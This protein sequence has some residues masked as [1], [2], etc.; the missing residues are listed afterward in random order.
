MPHRPIVAV[1][2]DDADIRELLAAYLAAQRFVVETATDAV[3]LDRVLANTKSVAG[4][5]GLDVTRRERSVRVPTP[6]RR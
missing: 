5:T 4:G 2:E 3:A 1:C 6:I